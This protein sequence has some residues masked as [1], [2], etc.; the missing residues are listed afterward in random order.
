MR[1]VKVVVNIVLAVLLLLDIALGF[2]VYTRGWPTRV[3][4]TEAS[5]GVETVSVSRLPFTTTDVWI[6]TALIGA[7]VLVVYLV[8]HF[9][10]RSHANA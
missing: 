9:H 5:P 7:Y 2:Q 4:L 10:K 6:L 1:W 3:T 8:W